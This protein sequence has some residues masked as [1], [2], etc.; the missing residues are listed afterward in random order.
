MLRWLLPVAVAILAG[1]GLLVAA[2]QGA[3]TTVKPLTV[4]GASTT[5]A[6]PANG[7]CKGADSPQGGYKHVIWIVMG[8]RD[9]NDVM[10]PTSLASNTKAYAAECGFA[11]QYVSA[12]HPALPNVPAMLAGTTAGITRNK[13]WPLPHRPDQPLQAGSKLE[14]LRWRYA[15]QLLVDSQA[16]LRP[17]HQ[18][19]DLDR[20]ARGDLPQ[21]GRAHGRPFQRSPHRDLKQQHPAPVLD[22]GTRPLPEHDVLEALLRRTAQIS[23]FVALGDQWLGQ[24]LGQIVRSPAYQ[25]GST[26]VFVTWQSGSGFPFKAD[27]VAKRVPRSCG[28]PMI[29]IAPSVTAGTISALNLSHYSLL[30]T[31]ESL[32]GVKHLG[33]AAKAR[34]RDMQVPFGL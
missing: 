31:S 34:T 4:P 6:V 12:A 25:S 33:E 24:R 18:P 8:T 30:K 16:E 9:T 28:V 21:A 1:I 13:L 14:S 5:G 10:S 2:G 15:R 19:P 27:C 32:F 11:Q 26:A 3:S 20:S 29:V 17:A 23:T 22:A 7:P